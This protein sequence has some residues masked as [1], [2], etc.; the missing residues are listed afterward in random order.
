MS[1]NK[2][3]S[4]EPGSRQISMAVVEA[5]EQARSKIDMRTAT[6]EES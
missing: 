6:S 5:V 4:G 3:A 2:Q 1:R